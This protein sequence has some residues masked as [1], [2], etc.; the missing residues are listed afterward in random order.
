[1]YPMNRPLQSTNRALL[2]PYLAPYGVYVVIGSFLGEGMSPEWNYALRILATTPLIIWAWRRYVPLIGPK[3]GWASAGIGILAG[4]AGAVLWIALKQ[5][6]FSGGG[7]ELGNLAFSLR[8]GATG[9]LVPIFEELLVRGYVFRLALQWDFARKSGAKQPVIIALDEQS[10]NNVTPGAWSV[11]AVVIS[12]AAFALGHRVP[13]WPA[14]IAFSLVMIV[15]WI[16]RKDLLSC[17]IA[18]GVT[19]ISLAYYV[20]STGHWGLW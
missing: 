19:N 12:T 15:L 14:A 3:S 4:F 8:L 2:I 5:P 20:L 7:S 13:E 17:V 6:F 10:I 9:F 1:M 11:W 16:N 18:H